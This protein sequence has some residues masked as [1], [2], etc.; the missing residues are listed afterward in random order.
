MEKVF[1]LFLL[2][3]YEFMNTFMN[4]IFILCFYA[5]TKMNNQG[6]NV[7]FGKIK[8]KACAL[9]GNAIKISEQAKEHQ[10]NNNFGQ[11]SVH[12]G[13]TQRVVSQIL[14][15][16]ARVRSKYPVSHFTFTYFFYWDIFNKCLHKES[17]YIQ[18]EL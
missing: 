17:H 5:H 2:L 15:P 8:L 12:T 3:L 13:A 16:G 10:H 11:V 7:H 6:G 1:F 4:Y 14:Q 9:C 18:F